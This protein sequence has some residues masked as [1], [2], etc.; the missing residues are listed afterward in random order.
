MTAAQIIIAK[1]GAPDGKYQAENCVL[2][3]IQEDGFPWFPVSHI[4][5][6]NLF[7]SMLFKSFTAVQAAGL[8]HEIISYNGCLVQRNVRGS[9]SV[10]AHAYGAAID[11]SASIDGMFIADGLPLNDPKRLGKWSKTFV[12]AMTSSG[13][14]FGGFFKHRSDPMHFSMVDM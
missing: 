7:K 14:F 1:Y 5:L 10:S 4:F 12:D 6:N 3:P 13:V 11:L 9:N 8:Q 2:W